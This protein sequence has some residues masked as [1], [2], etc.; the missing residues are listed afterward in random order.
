MIDLKDIHKNYTVRGKVIPALNGFDLSIVRGEIF[1][2]IGHSG[3]G[4]STLIRLIN[5]LERPTQGKIVV[6]GEDILAFDETALRNFRR[7]IGMIFQH[8]NLLNSKTVAENIAFPLKIKGESDKGKIDARVNQMLELVGLSKH[9]HK[10]PKQLSGGEKQRVGIARALANQPKILLCDEA[11][12]AL[13][14]QTTRSIL[15]LLREINEKLKL[16]IVLITHEMDVIRT[17]CDR[18]AVIDSGKIVEQGPVTR[19]FLHPQHPTTR[20]FVL[21]AENISDDDMAQT[22]GQVSDGFIRRLT[23]INASIEEPVLTRVARECE[24]DFLILN[25]RFGKIKSTL[26]GQVTVSIKGNTARANTAWAKLA[27]AGVI[28]EENF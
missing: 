12:S 11:T 16:T 23:F 28:V 2:V 9:K 8:F 3:A 24:V 22:L 15:Q 20:N 25:G 18:V 4:K 7:N 17:I 27:D 1:G 6:D 13:D 26:C 21:E 14:P 5:L 10:Y 19:V